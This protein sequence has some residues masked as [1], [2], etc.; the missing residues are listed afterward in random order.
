MEVIPS[1]GIILKNNADDYI[2]RL[3]I[4][5]HQQLRKHILESK[6]DLKMDRHMGQDKTIVLVR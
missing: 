2:G 5:G 3:Q 4:P 6:H 1:T